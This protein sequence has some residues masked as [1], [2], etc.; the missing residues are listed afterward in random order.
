MP[1]VWT[2]PDQSV[3]AS[4][5][6]PATL[7][8]HEKILTSL[9]ADGKEVAGDLQDAQIGAFEPRSLRL[10]NLTTEQVSGQLGTCKYVTSTIVR[11]EK[12]SDPRLVFGSMFKCGPA[13]QAAD[14]AFLSIVIRDAHVE[15]VYFLPEGGM[16]VV[17]KDKPNG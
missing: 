4:S 16:P 11:D 12:A 13:A 2:W 14:L 3:E 6:Q 5:I 9:M 1:T 7:S 15:G 10:K 17:L 8:L